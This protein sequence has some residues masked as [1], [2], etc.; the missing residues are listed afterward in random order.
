VGARILGIADAFDAMVSDR[1]YRRG[2]TPQ[3]A[4]AELRRCSGTQFDPE[5]VEKFIAVMSGESVIRLSPDQVSS[6]E[7]DGVAARIGME[8]EGLTAAV[9]AGQV[10][11]LTETSTR[12]A[13][14]A[15]DAGLGE[16]ERT[17]RRVQGASHG[18]LSACMDAAQELLALCRQ[19]AERQA[20]TPNMAAA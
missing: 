3:E 14:I 12:L 11:T 7:S 15:A 8:L 6:V 1:P 17:A 18:D 20:P 19:A 16:L 9:A 13:R 5:L 4:F 2:R 10:Q